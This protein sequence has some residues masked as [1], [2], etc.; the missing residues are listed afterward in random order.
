[1]YSP[2]Y[3]GVGTGS[4]LNRA[5][6]VSKVSTVSPL[7]FP[8]QRKQIYGG[9][10]NQASESASGFPCTLA[11]VPDCRP[12]FP[13]VFFGF[14]VFAWEILQ[15]PILRLVCATKTVYQKFP[16]RFQDVSMAEKKINDDMLL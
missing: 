14:R 7:V 4:L 11:L 9:G 13:P 15:V 16:W 10:G 1:M 12:N 2:T 3:Q 6:K 5:P 8:W